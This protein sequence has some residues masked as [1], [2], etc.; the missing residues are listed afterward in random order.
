M[1]LFIGM[2]M[3]FIRKPEN[4]ITAKPT[5]VAMAISLISIIS[6]KYKLDRRKNK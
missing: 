1:M 5:N 4:P 2:K 6:K 3:S